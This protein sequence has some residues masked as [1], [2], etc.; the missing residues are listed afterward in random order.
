MKKKSFL[1]SLSK[2]SLRPSLFNP[3]SF[4]LSLSLSRLPPPTTLNPITTLLNNVIPKSSIEVE[5]G[6]STGVHLDDE[7]QP[8]TQWPPCQTPSNSNLWLNFNRDL[9]N[10]K[11][12]THKPFK[13]STITSNPKLGSTWTLPRNPN[14]MNPRN[15][16]PNLN[17]QIPKPTQINLKPWSIHRS[18]Y[19]KPQSMLQNTKSHNKIS[20]LTSTS[21]HTIDSKNLPSLSWPS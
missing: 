18:T 3:S 6:S 20:I 17:P 11:L 4:L 2:L 8:R 5:S 9:Q 21:K 13:P 7:H 10:F 19:P 1:R 16:N 14:L 15:P 12:S